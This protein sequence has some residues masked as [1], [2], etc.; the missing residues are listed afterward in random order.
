M[1]SCGPPAGLAVA[2]VPPRS[3]SRPAAC[4]HAAERP[5]APS[6]AACAR[7]CT[8]GSVQRPG[9][10]AAIMTAAAAGEAGVALNGACGPVEGC[11]ARQAPSACG[12]AG[13][14]PM[15]CVPR[16][17]PARPPSALRP[18]QR[19][20][21]TG[22]MPRDAPQCRAA[23]CP[24]FPARKSAR[25]NGSTRHARDKAVRSGLGPCRARAAAA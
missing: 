12:A 6:S 1:R 23:S 24:P 4:G 5:P 14:H 19:W 13:R 8:R 18:R 3:G 20:R 7:T 16:R 15:R 21:A 2:A 17:P 11:R 25:G 9:R 22:R 10:G